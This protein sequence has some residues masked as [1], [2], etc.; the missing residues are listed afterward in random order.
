LRAVILDNLRSAWNVGSVFRSAAALQYHSIA[1]CGVTIT[2]PAKKL[3]ETSRGM[4]DQIE[5]KAHHSTVE[6]IAEYKSKGFKVVALESHENAISMRQ[7]GPVEQVA[8]VLGNEA[9]GISPSA[10]NQCDEMIELP[11]LSE[12][13]GIN[14][15][16]AFAAAAYQDYFMSFPHD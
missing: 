1:L 3:R 12:Q 4:E 5:W 16:C 6:A 15:S 11:M 2:P 10:L 7:W 9:M 14:V 13:T 8:F